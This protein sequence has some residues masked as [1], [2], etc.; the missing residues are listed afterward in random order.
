MRKFGIFTFV[1]F[2]S[3]AVYANIEFYPAKICLN[4]HSTITG[5]ASSVSFEHGKYIYF[6]ETGDSVVEK[7]ESL[8]IDT[9]IYIKNDEEISYMYLKVYKGW[10]QKKIT[11]NSLWLQ[12]E[13]KG[14]CTL[15]TSSTY[16]YH[17]GEPRSNIE[18]LDC[19]VIRKGEPA[20]KLI[21]TITSANNN[22]TFRAKAPLYFAD[23]PE[24]ANKIKEKVYTWKNI[25]EVIDIYNSW[26]V[27]NQ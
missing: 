3:A 13:K 12:I 6:K 25:E 11:E 9:L 23:Y 14:I 5:L 26:A 17:L 8:T 7:I 2:L 20:A 24:L 21:A 19:Y 27:K 18:F 10:K 15:L 1:L 22:Q 4:D 16:I